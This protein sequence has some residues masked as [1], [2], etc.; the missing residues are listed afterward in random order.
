MRGALAI[1]RHILRI[2]TLATRATGHATLPT[3]GRSGFGTV[4]AAACATRSGSCT[5]FP[6]KIRD[7]VTGFLTNPF[8]NLRALAFAAFAGMGLLAS[9]TTA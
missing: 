2:V 7:V 8:M 6:T 9:A 5:T 4:S 1:R 3:S